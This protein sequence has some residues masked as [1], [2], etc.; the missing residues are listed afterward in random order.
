MKKYLS[1]LFIAITFTIVL[2]GCNGSALYNSLNTSTCYVQVSDAVENKSGS[3]ATYDY[4]LTGYNKS[5]D[6]KEVKLSENRRLRKDAYL[7]VKLKANDEVMGWE[8]VE[9]K[10][11]PQKVKEK[12]D[13]KE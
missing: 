11:I 9:T 6:S 13:I 12:L 5:G 7:R 4:N 10:D 3:K 1:L 8:E 2:G